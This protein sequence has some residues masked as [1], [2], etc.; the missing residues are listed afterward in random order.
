MIIRARPKYILGTDNLPNKFKVEE[1]E[2]FFNSGRA[3][4][5][6]FLK[7]FSVKKNKQLVLG[8]QAFNCSVVLDSAL[9]ANC[10][11]VLS[12]I[13]LKSF[14]VSINSVKK[15]AE[16]AK[17]D[18]LLLTHYQGIPCFDYKK[19]INF[20]KKNNI[21]VIEDMALT[22]GSYIDGVLVGTQGYV[23][24]NSYAFDKPFSCLHGGSLKFNV[25]IE[26]SFKDLFNKL[27][28][29]TEKEA[30]H[31]I[32]VLY[33]L[34]KYTSLKYYEEG[35]DN[36]EIISFLKIIGLNNR[37]IY[38]ILCQKLFSK[39]I[40]K[41]IK[42]INFFNKKKIKVKKLHIK[43][44]NLVKKQIKNFYYNIKNE[45]FIIKLCKDNSIVYPRVNKLSFI[46]WNRFSVI[47]RQSIL[48]KIL[49]KKNYQVS[50]YNW[51]VT[52]DKL[53][54]KNDVK[55]IESLENSILASKKVVNIPIWN[56][57]E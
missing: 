3:A 49:K 14:S 31:H 19:I 40:Y 24:I 51:P 13:S 28:K 36:Y 16:D 43:K 50:N 35:V 29:E 53:V 44:I 5:K 17:I 57:D 22:Y 33:F 34:M 25:K 4:L 47:D 26:K 21:T 10:K 39:L 27:P 42:F 48:K 30:S 37:L 56:L 32:K 54:K 55:I 1:N 18:L 38:F 11:V 46:Y 20:C 2:F 23:S 7:W 9:E 6:F 45:N 15:M 12:D 52:L 41:N 8:M